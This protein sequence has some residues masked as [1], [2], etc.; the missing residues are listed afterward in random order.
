MVE[1]PANGSFNHVAKASF[2]ATRHTIAHGCGQTL[3]EIGRLLHM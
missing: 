3:I 1:V 2:D